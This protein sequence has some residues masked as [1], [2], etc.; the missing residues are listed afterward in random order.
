MK[1]EETKMSFKR[2]TLSA[3]L[4]LAGLTLLGGGS[5]PGQISSLGPTAAG[6]ENGQVRAAIDWIDFALRPNEKWAFLEL[7]IMPLDTRSIT[8]RR[9]DI[10]LV[11]PDGA[12]LAVP[13]QA[14]LTMGYPDIR[15]IMAM[16]DVPQERIGNTFR[17]RKD[18]QR[19][20]FH[21]IPGAPRFAFDSCTVGPYAAGYGDI[22]FFNPKGHWETGLYT[23]EVKTEKVDIAIPFSL[24]VPR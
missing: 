4:L 8:I 12:R 13:E 21:E 20:G 9:G 18:T 16:T 2:G 3:M 22:F 7:W 24:A 23:L 10:I 6:F 14:V 5:R 19:F 1:G 17:P 11:L 15:R